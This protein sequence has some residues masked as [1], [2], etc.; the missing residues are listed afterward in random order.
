MI[1][2]K[3]LILGALN[4]PLEESG[5]FLPS[6]AKRAGRVRLKLIFSTLSNLRGS[7]QR[8]VFSIWLMH[9][10]SIGLFAKSSQNFSIFKIRNRR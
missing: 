5:F 1:H 10:D 2:I 3:H 6:N 4:H 7:D 8:G 9:K